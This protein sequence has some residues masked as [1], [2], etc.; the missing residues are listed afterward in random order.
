MRRKKTLVPVT[1]AIPAIGGHLGFTESFFF[2]FSI[3]FHNFPTSLAAFSR[4]ILEMYSL[5]AD[6]SLDSPFL[7]PTHS[8]LLVAERRIPLHLL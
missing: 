3:R 4:C 8:I 2:A 1:S 5:P 7:P 6:T